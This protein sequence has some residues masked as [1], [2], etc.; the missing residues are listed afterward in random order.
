MR[1]RVSSSNKEWIRDTT[2]KLPC[3][4]SVEKFWNSRS[5]TK[6]KSM[7]NFFLEGWY[8]TIVIIFSIH[9]FHQ[10]SLHWYDN[11]WLRLLWRA[12][13]TLMLHYWRH[14]YLFFSESWI[15]T[16]HSELEIIIILNK[17]FYTFFVKTSQRNVSNRKSE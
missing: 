8:W 5:N 12:E 2:T 3:C 9:H 16:F 6:I 17:Y 13:R 15:S 4:T 11:Q 7:T 10:D 1:K 14:H